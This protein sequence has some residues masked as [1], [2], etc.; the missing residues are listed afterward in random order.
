MN[1]NREDVQALGDVQF[2][3][4]KQVTSSLKAKQVQDSFLLSGGAV[5]GDLMSGEAS[6]SSPHASTN[7]KRKIFTH[8]KT[9]A[10][11]GKKPRKSDDGHHTERDSSRGNGIHGGK[12]DMEK[13]QA[14]KTLRWVGLCELY[15]PYHMLLLP[16]ARSSYT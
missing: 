12:R 4:R 11:P 8:S 9:Q 2:S 1:T 15:L 5:F 14:R 6:V 13:V 7:V 16:M 3:K 10:I